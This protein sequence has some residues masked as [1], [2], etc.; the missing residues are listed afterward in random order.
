M[1]SAFQYQ[2][3]TRAK[4]SKAGHPPRRGSWLSIGGYGELERLAHARIQQS[5]HRRGWSHARRLNRQV[6]AKVF[7]EGS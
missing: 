6:M 5:M 7:G 3:A 2:D 4:L 1:Y